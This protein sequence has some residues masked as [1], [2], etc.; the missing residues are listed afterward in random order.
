[1]GL[2]HAAAY[3]GLA[4]VRV[5]AIVDRHPD[6][7]LAT[8]GWF[9]DVEALLA[10]ATPDLAS[11]ATPPHTHRLVAEKLLRAGVRVLVEKP[12]ATTVADSEALVATALPG[13][14]AVGHLERANAAVGAL[15]RAIAGQRIT[16]IE[17]VRSGPGPDPV[18]QVG[19]ALD[20]AVHDLDLAAYLLEE[21]LRVVC[22]ETST[23]GTGLETMLHGELSAVSGATVSITATVQSGPGVRTLCVTTDRHVL[24]ADLLRHRLEMDGR[25]VP[26]LPQDALREQ[27]S[28]LRDGR[29][30][31]SGLDGLLSVRLA[32]DLLRVAGPS[33]GGSCAGS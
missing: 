27:L 33:R 32:H 9:Q 22:A 21:Q 25:E 20:L 14:L 31:A 26:I 4:G 1:M 7:R 13:T 8:V 28:G 30:L 6:R 3:G 12:L 24:V 2:R 16:R 5:I 23:D 19:A 15:R 17:A 18:H 11:V 29:P 10:T